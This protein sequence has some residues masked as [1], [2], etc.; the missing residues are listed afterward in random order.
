M[1][2]QV[3]DKS[4]HSGIWGSNVNVKFFEDGL[5]IGCNHINL[6]LAENDIYIGSLAFSETT[7][8]CEDCNAYLRDDE[9]VLPPV[10]ERETINWEHEK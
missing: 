7:T 4:D 5:L 8:Y 10:S 9:W 3:Q 1:R 2:I 6:E